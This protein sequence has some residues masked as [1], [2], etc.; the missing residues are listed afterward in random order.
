MPD[1]ARLL[2]IPAPTEEVVTGRQT[3]GYNDLI[4]NVVVESAQAIAVGLSIVAWDAR[5]C[6]VSRQTAGW[7]WELRHARRARAA[8]DIEARARL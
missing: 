1:L 7:L 6:I 4:N 5:L 8:S 3:R 2:A